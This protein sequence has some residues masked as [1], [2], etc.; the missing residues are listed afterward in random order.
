MSLSGDS[1]NY[2]KYYGTVS[3]PIKVS[4]YIYKFKVTSI[5]YSD[6]IGSS[7][8]ENGATYTM[9]SRMYF[10]NPDYIYLYLPG[11]PMSAMKHTET[12]GF[13]MQP[14]DQNNRLI[15]YY[16]AIY[17]SNDEVGMHATIN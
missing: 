1:V 2:S 8:K 9:T 10:K 7:Y 5:H 14:A 16:A 6:A 11:A 13:Q 12:Y 3:A 4:D 17:S 15:S